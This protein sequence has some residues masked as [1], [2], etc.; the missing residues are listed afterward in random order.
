MTTITCSHPED[1]IIVK[2]DVE[3][4]TD[5]LIKRSKPYPFCESCR[6]RLPV[7]EKPGMQMVTFWFIRQDNKVRAQMA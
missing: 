2:Q 1:K 6:S 4:T 3:R 7:Y 5:V